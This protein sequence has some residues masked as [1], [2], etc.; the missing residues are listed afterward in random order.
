MPSSKKGSGKSSAS[1][2][3]RN[4]QAAKKAK[5]AGLDGQP[6]PDVPV[7]PKHRG[8]K[9]EKRSK[10]EPKRKVFI[11]PP[12]PPQPIPDPLDTLG[13]ASLLPPGLVLLLRK[14]AKK[15]VI[16]RSRALEG[17]INWIDGSQDEAESA[18][19][20][21]EERQSALVMMLPS[22]VS[23]SSSFPLGQGR[24]AIRVSHSS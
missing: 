15:D 6:Q 4:K 9:K 20:A 22:W 23:V 17:L 5:K 1:S 19:M 8:E 18:E 7:Q 14:A 21:V 11:P 24:S 10:K 13:L 2:A 3:T 16:T 12:K